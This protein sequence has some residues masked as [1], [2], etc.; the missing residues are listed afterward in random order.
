MKQKSKRRGDGTL[1]YVTL[2]CSH[3]GKARNHI[4][5]VARPRSTSK[6]NCRAR[7]NA[8][9]IDGFLFKVLSMQ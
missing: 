1:R 8:M 6:L 7:I 9:L 4:S 5:N 2:G 3:G